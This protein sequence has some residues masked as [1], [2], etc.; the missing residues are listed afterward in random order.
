MACMHSVG[1]RASVN[2]AMCEPMGPQDALVLAAPPDPLHEFQLSAALKE[3]R[4]LLQRD[5]QAIETP[6]QELQES[7]KLLVTH[8]T[9]AKLACKADLFEAFPL[10]VYEKKPNN[11]ELANIQALMEIGPTVKVLLEAFPA[12]G[13]AKQIEQALWSAPLTQCICSRR[14]E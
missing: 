3:V 10:G 6:V 12:S 9:D 1:P 14:A 5:Q 13:R 7:V 11:H 4:D 2:V 8:I